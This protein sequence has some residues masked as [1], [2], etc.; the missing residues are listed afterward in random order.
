MS[1][2]PLAPHPDIRYVQRNN[3]KQNRAVSKFCREAFIFFGASSMAKHFFAPHF[4]VLFLTVILGGLAR[5]S[6]A[7]ITLSPLVGGLTAPVDIANA[8]DGS[9]RLFVVEQAGRIRIVQNGFLLPTPFLD[10]TGANSIISGG[11]ERGLLGLAF[12]P[13]YVSNGQF[14]I[15]F[16]S[17]ANAGVATGDIVIARYQQ[18]PTDA[19]RA[20]AASRVNIL[21]IPHPGQANHNGGSLRF[22]PDGFLYAGVGD[23]GGV[24]DPLNS[25]QTL[26]TLLG[27]ILRINV[28]D[29]P[30][31]TIPTNNPFR[32]VGGARAEIWAYGVRNPWRISFDRANGDFYIGDVGQN[33]WEEVNR[34]SAGGVG[35]ANYGWRVCEGN[36]LYPESVPAVNCAPPANYV[37][38][39]LEYSHTVAPVGHSVTGGYVYRGLSTPDLAGQYVFGDFQDAKLFV[40][41]GTGGVTQL[42]GSGLT[43]QVSTFGEGE[44]GELYLANYATGVISSFSSATDTLPD[45][46]TFFAVTNVPMGVPIESNLVK[47]TGLGTVANISI[48]GVAGAGGEFTLSPSNAASCSSSYR[49]GSSTVASDTYVCVRMTSASTPNTTRTTTLTIGPSTFSFTTT[50]GAGP[51]LFDVTPTVGVNGF[52]SPNQVQQVASGQTAAFSITP[53]AGYA[54]VVTGTCGGTLNGTNYV[55]NPV[56]QNCTVIATFN[57]VFTVTPSAGANGSIAPGS[58]QIV[59]LNATPI[60]TVT[61]NA[62][63]TAS[64]VGTC[65]GTLVGTT[66]TTN[67]ITANCTVTAIFGAIPVAPDA[68]II[69]LAVPGDNAASIGFSPPANNGGATITL[70]TVTCDAGAATATGAA[71]PITVSG[72]AND[73]DHACSVTATNSMGTGPASATVNV[74][75]TASAPLQRVAVKSRKNHAAAGS[76]SIPIDTTAA[77]SNSPTVEPRMI[78]S[79]HRIVFEFNRAITAPG[80]AVATDAVATQIGAATTATSGNDVIVTLTDIPDNQRV[81]VTLSDVNGPGF[82]TSVSI[83]FLVGDVNGSLSVNASDISAIKAR[84]SQAIDVSKFRFDLNASGA[85]DASD[86]SAA[87]ARSG[88]VIGNF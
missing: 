21:T 27:K 75:P 16:T 62:G 4:F 65:G 6:F 19:N 87:K 2:C 55:T 69:G 33:A 59:G 63:F 56:T 18:L 71:S 8:G 54:A 48:A 22:G 15:Y 81:T 39:I 5:P 17:N 66:F 30:T 42:S 25:A 31:Y 85:I 12:H 34:Q 67:G 44:T 68:P 53:L 7:N 41:N 13:Q 51:M 83:A 24:G 14:F 78:G 52:L 10:L 79:G 50:T 64:V 61:P 86:V 38:P 80:T 73:T 84:T 57:S 88:R 45:P 26:S 20:D 76:F 77:L 60:F 36:H 32:F 82:G 11:G 58:V 29:V 1:I 43:P 46:L 72:L 23:G 9:G 70:Y 49:P 35:G 40:P 47:I 3:K 28:T 74:R 37:A